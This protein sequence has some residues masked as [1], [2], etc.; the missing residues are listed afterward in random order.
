MKKLIT[1]TFAIMLLA[2]GIGTFVPNGSAEF[3]SQDYWTQEA[4]EYS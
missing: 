4:N 2:G 3:G 1:S